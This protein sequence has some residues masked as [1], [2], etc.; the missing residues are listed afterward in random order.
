MAAP[1]TAP[2]VSHPLKAR[3]EKI[4]GGVPPEPGDAA[5][6]MVREV[7]PGTRFRYRLEVKQGGIWRN[8]WRLDEAV[9]LVNEFN[10]RELTAAEVWR[11]NMRLVS[12]RGGGRR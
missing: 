2:L 3:A 5:R 12:R 7:R 11:L 1:D 4:G 10:R 9:G 8:E 6:V